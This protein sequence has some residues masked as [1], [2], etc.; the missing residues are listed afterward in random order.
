MLKTLEFGWD[1]K[2]GGIFYFLDRDN[3]PPQELQWDQ[4]LWWVH[5]EVNFQIL[6]FS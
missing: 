6:E 4:K 3:K 1:Q 2:Y 5:L